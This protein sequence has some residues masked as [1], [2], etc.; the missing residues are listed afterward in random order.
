MDGERLHA[1]EREY[2]RQ[3][4]W[5]YK[6]DPYERRKYD[7]T[8]ALVPPGRYRRALE[9]GCSEGVFT[10]RL[11]PL[12]DDVLGLDI[13][14]VA[15]ARARRECAGLPN[16]RFR[17]FDLIADALDERFDLIFC[18]EVLYYVRWTR[19]RAVTRKITTWLR[20][21]GYLIAV[22][23][24][25]EVAAEWQFGPKGA[26]RTHRLFE[27]P[28]MRRLC[29]QDEGRYVLT[30]FQKTR[31]VPVSPWRES[32]EILRGFAHPA[33]AAHAFRRA[34][35]IPQRTERTERTEE[36]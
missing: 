31:D 2:E 23:V 6:T 11:A 5:G 24:K 21:G 34:F 32:V 29:D 9:I 15:L 8:L 14:D 7:Q 20:P 22:H 19:L 10:R 4:H 3:D 18:A 26:E 12:A 36:A 35:G 33:L 1:L 28:G 30:L 13:V 27:R 16:V 17:R 25:S